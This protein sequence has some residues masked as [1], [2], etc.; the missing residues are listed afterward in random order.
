MPLAHLALQV[1]KFLGNP[2]TQW[3]IIISPL[4]WLQS[5]WP[6]VQRADHH[7]VQKP[8]CGLSRMIHILPAPASVTE[9]RIGTQGLGAAD[10]HW[11]S[12]CRRAAKVGPTSHAC[13]LSWASF[14]A[15][16]DWSTLENH[17]KPLKAEPPIC[18]FHWSHLGARIFGH[19]DCTTC[20]TGKLASCDK[21]LRPNPPKSCFFPRWLLIFRLSHRPNYV[22]I[23]GNCG[24]I[25][26]KTPRSN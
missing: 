13:G 14:Y 26:H 24:Y 9:T 7:F 4:E 25:P 19:A 8:P 23:W 3:L 18:I 10:A 1:W 20:A 11:C 5:R 15:K 16:K 17:G 2:Q 12:M 6:F 21:Q 22:K